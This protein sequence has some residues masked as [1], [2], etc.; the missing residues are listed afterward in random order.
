MELADGE[1]INYVKIVHG[2]WTDQG[3]FR[4]NLGNTH[5]WGGDGGPVTV[6]LV[7]P[8]GARVISFYGG[9]DGEL[10]SFGCYYIKPPRP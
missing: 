7:I 10:H 8:R 3:D 2:G 5:H 9:Y 6:S 4:T 1:F